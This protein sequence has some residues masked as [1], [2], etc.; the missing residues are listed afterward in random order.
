MGVLE[1]RKQQGLRKQETVAAAEPGICPALPGARRGAES[2]V[3]STS[4]G[5]HSRELLNK[6]GGFQ[7]AWAANPSS[8][9]CTQLCPTLCYPMDCSPPGSSVHWILQA[10]ILEWVAIS[11]SRGSSQP[12]DQTHVSCI[13]REILNHCATWEAPSLPF[14]QS[15]SDAVVLL[16]SMFLSLWK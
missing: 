15:V 6:A 11:F 9:D 2:L 7:P 14:C 12:R 3:R 16:C 13:G 8:L 4:W 5:P 10:T 1:D